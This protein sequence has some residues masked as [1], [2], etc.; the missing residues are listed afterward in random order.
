MIIFFSV[1]YQ[2]SIILTFQIDD[3][4]LSYN[5]FSG[6]LNAA[7]GRL[8]QLKKLNLRDC[9]LKGLPDWIDALAQVCY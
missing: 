5:D 8:R 1:Q 4:D 6:G 2:F 9:I 7:L 3:L